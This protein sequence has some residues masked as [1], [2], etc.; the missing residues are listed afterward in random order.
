MPSI[1]DLDHPDIGPAL[2]QVVGSEAR[3]RGLR[4]IEFMAYGAGAVP[5]RIECM[6]GA[7]SPQAQ[8]IVLERRIDWDAKIAQAKKLAGI[9]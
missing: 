3:A 1:A 7:G 9:E 2:R 6:H 8:R 4:L 5:L